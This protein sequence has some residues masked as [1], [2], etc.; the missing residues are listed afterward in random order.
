MTAERIERR[1]FKYLTDEATAA[2]V[3]AAARPFCTLDEHGA[4]RPGGRYTI[5]SLYLDTPTLELYRANGRELH[6]RFKLRVRDYPPDTHGPVFLEVKRRVGD[7]IVKTR[8]AVPRK[9]WTAL[10]E[11]PRVPMPGPAV[12][13]FVALLHT[14]QAGPACLVRYERE[15]WVSQVD[16]YA[17]VTIDRNIRCQIQERLDLEAD[18]GG[19]RNVDHAALQQTEDAM[20]VVELKFTRAV[21]R[22]MVNIVQSLDLLRSAFSK[23]GTAIQTWNTVP[24]FMTSSLR[25]TA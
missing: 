8:A 10:I 1:E 18:P 23:Y 14:H 17:R 11:D 19:W 9:Q 5:N 7:A 6:D 15:A 24:R 3:R 16:G 2:A 12:E 4:S 20:T 13:R 21:P 25:R 22:W